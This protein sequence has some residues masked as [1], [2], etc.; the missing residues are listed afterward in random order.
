MMASCCPP[1]L[2]MSRPTLRVLL[3]S[4]YTSDEIVRRGLGEPGIEY[5]QKPF[6]PHSLAVKV[7]AVLDAPVSGCADDS[8][9]MA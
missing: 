5:L 3:M 7:R 6:T 1:P 4:G 9:A 2:S 8:A